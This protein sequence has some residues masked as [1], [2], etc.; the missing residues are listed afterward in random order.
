M[1]LKIP[2][3]K[4]SNAVAE[5]RLWL[6]TCQGFQEIRIRPGCRHVACLHAHVISFCLLTE[7]IFNCVYEVQKAYLIGIADIHDAVA[8]H[9]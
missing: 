4:F 1:I 3:H 9:G 2:V 6:I 5:V 8:G 7:A